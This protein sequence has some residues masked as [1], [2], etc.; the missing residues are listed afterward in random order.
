MPQYARFAL[1]VFTGL[2]GLV[3]LVGAGEFVLTW[4][5]LVDLAAIATAVLL[6]INK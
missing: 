1:I 4:K 5:T 3:G 6:G 2:F